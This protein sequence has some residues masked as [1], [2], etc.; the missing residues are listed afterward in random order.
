MQKFA[1]DLGFPLIF[2]AAL[3]SLAVV[4]AM[5]EDYGDKTKEEIIR[6]NQEKGI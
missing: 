6:L 5:K 2:I 3:M 4:R 1:I